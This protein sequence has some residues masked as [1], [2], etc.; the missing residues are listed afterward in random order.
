MHKNSNDST[1]KLNIVHSPRD[2]VWG[3]LY[4]RDDEYTHKLDGI[5]KGYDRKN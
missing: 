1:G 5:E 2:I 4:E 3:V